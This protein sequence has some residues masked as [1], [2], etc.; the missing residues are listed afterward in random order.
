[1]ALACRLLEGPDRDLGA[2]A[3]LAAALLTRQGLEAA[4][5]RWWQAVLPAMVEATGRDQ[6]V[7]L[8][9]YLDDAALAGEVTWAWNRLSRLCHHTAY[10][11][12]PPD[13]ELRHLLDTVTRFAR[14]TA[15][16]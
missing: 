10:E 4:L 5:T 11:L 12:P 14:T 15:H 1:M 3:T 9:F 16:R 6:L 7:S 8:P 13:H 2:D